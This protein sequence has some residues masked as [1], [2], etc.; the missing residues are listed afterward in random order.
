MGLCFGKR[1]S[2]ENK[3]TSNQLLRFKEK[4]SNSDEVDDY[5]TV[6]LHHD[7]FSDTDSDL[8]LDDDTSSDIDSMDEEVHISESLPLQWS[9]G[10]STED[11]HH[12]NS[13]K[14]FPHPLL[15]HV[16]QEASEFLTESTIELRRD[17]GMLNF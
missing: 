4:E 9:N 13:P 14:R 8:S 6:D 1:K 17:P 10:S 3:I 2:R 15:G 5:I 12:K 16:G 7:E 11:I